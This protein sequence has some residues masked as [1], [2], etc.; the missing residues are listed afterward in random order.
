MTGF[1]SLRERLLDEIRRR[2]HNGEGTE[3]GLARASG[4]S[5][6]H[7]HNL[8]KGIRGLNTATSDQLLTRLGINI[9][10]LL[11][12]DELR[13]ALYLRVMEEQTAVEIPVLKTR[14]GPGLPFTGEPSEFERVRVPLSYVAAA[15]NPVVARLSDDAGMDPVLASGDLVMLDV[16]DNRLA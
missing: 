1:A 3:R 9:T 2:V 12:A 15:G 6:P 5:Q 7:M 11:K 13:R 16:S 4:I 14:L 10:D 8:L